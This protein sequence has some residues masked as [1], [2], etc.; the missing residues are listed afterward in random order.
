M[1]NQVDSLVSHLHETD[2]HD[3]ENI[4]T[5]T[6]SGMNIK[7]EEAENVSRSA[8]DPEKGRSTTNPLDT[9]SG[10]ENLHCN[11]V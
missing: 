5:T 2:Q 11:W 10:T 4:T 6:L 9:L 3:I 8:E 1:S 7:D